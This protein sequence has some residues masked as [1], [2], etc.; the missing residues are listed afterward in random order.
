MRK[1][2]SMLTIAQCWLS[3]LAF[4]QARFITVPVINEKGKAVPAA[5]VKIQGTT[6]G[7]D[8]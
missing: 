2:A 7:G 6:T 1:I 5:S 8:Y 4:G 3:A